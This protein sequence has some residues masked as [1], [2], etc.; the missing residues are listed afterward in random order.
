MSQEILDRLQRVDRI[1]DGEPLVPKDAATLLILERKADGDPHVL[2]GRRHMRHKFMP[3]M[4]VFPGGRVDPEDVGVRFAADYDPTVQSKLTRDLKGE[5]EEDYTRAFAIAAVRETYEEAGLFIGRLDHNDTEP[6]GHG[7]EA[8]DN[9]FVMPD[10]SPMRF[11][12][13]AITPPG[14]PRRYDTRFLAVWSDQIADRLPE[15]TGPSGELEELQWL[16]LEESKQLELPPITLAVIEELQNR[17]AED[18]K[19]EPD[20]PVP[21]YYWTPEGFVREEL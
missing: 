3:G 20:Y 15:G 2:M 19:L 14:R 11:V 9:R 16:S 21:Y 7:F 5:E 17:L 1:L 4:F 18:P 12:A 6:C 10:L 13:R 8:F